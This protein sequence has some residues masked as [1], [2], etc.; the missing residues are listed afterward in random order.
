[1][2][3]DELV[4]PITAAAL[5]V[6]VLLRRLLPVSE[7][8]RGKTPIFF[9]LLSIVLRVSGMALDQFEGGETAERVVFLVSTLT[10]AYGLTQLAGLILIDLGLGVVGVRIPSILRDLIQ[11]ISFL[12]SVL[13]VLSDHGL[14][15]VSLVTTSAVLTAV[16]GL[17]LQDTIANFFS[18]LSLQVDRTLGVGDW[19]Q[20]GDRVGRIVTIKWR[21][22][23]IITKDGDYVT[24]PNSSFLKGELKNYSRPT[25][26]HRVWCKVGF[27][28]RHPPNEVKRA[29]LDAIKGAPG[30]VET[31]P[32]DVL[33][34]EFADSAVFYALRYWIIDFEHDAVIDGEVRTRIWYAAQRH[35]LEIPFP[36][37]TVYMNQVTGEQ[38]ARDDERDFLER[39]GAL[40]KIE[41]FSALDDAD[42]E[43]LAKGMRKMRFAVGERIIRQGEPGDS[44]YLVRDGEVA[45][46]LAV[47]GAE[48]EVAKLAGGD[49]FG[50]M[51]LVTGEPR[52]A[53][54]V[55]RTVA[56]C[57]VVGHDAFK[58]LIHAKPKV[59]EEMSVVLGQRQAKLDGERE[60]LSAEARSRRASETQSRLLARM[61]KFFRMA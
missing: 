33:V 14:N 21:A 47:E 34:T 30:V 29:L 44:L 1:M 38:A 8:D 4:L 23:T 27:A 48:R 36:I 55:A 42:V 39:L 5:V 16:I 25:G 19:I 53:N 20:V 10:L 40:S 2:T 57:Y 12:V 31:P 9:L 46:T 59:A 54:V 37:R 3:L 32:S 41:L 7:R 56:T 45:V 51:S 52:A 60:G 24:V 35:G 18:G 49:F 15:L 28:Y 26:L 22:T 6:F 11:G 61:K 13:G 17:A 50:E 43:L 58:L